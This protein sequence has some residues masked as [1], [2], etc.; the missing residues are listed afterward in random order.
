MRVAADAGGAVSG[1]VPPTYPYERLGQLHEMAGRLEG[2]AV[3]C[4]IGTPCDPPPEVARRALAASTHANSYPPSGGTAAFRGA[5]AAY[6]ER[7]LAVTVDAASIA[8]CVGTKEL[9]ASSA[10]YLRL[11]T[12]ARDTVLYPSVSYPTY[13]MGA[14]LAGCRAVGVPPAAD[15]GLDLSAVPDADAAR[16]LVLWVNSP[17][18]PTGALSDLGAIASWGRARKVPVFSDECYAAYTWEGPARSILSHGGQGVVAV[19]SISKRSNLAGVRAGFFCGD[20]EIVAYLKLVRSHA[21]LMVAGPVQEAAAAAWRDSDHVVAQRA[22]YAERLELLARALSDAGCPTLTPPGSFYLWVE[23]P[24]RWKDGWE[25]AR[26]L[27]RVAG[28]VVSPGDLYGEE[29]CNHVRI[30]V[31][32]PTERLELVAR[33]LKVSEW[34]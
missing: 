23:V 17:A 33:R 28:L 15:G 2:G 5:A 10:H 7:E 24:E 27:A 9:V 30:A 34:R 25:L 12:P 19:H 31:V 21:G 22:R 14:A 26:D 6:L 3:D 11:R 16:A 20:E 4:S 18:N 1:F 32:Q 8:A 29:S 13:A